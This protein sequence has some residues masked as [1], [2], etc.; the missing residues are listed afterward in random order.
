MKKCSPKCQTQEF[1]VTK[2]T[3]SYPKK[4][5][6]ESILATKRQVMAKFRQNQSITYESLKNNMAAFDLYYETLDY[7]IISEVKY[8]PFLVLIANTGG[9]FGLFLGMS[10]LSFVE[11]IDLLIRLF[12]EIYKGFKKEFKIKLR[13]NS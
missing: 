1:F 11:L 10:I 13:F 4:K 6:A 3:A 5:Y 7:A 8:T 12:M 9:I 2:S